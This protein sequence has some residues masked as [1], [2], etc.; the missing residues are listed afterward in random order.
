MALS[1]CHSAKGYIENA[2]SD[3]YKLNGL[4]NTWDNDPV[5]RLSVAIDFI[6]E[7][8]Q[9][10]DEKVGKNHIRLRVKEKHGHPRESFYDHIASMIFEVIF[11]A[12]AV[13]S[14]SWEC[15]T[16]QHNSVWGKLFDFQRMNNPA[17]SIV[18]FKLRRLLYDEVVRMKRFP[19]FKGAKILSFCLNVMGLESSQDSHDRDSR[20]LHKAILAWTKKNYAWLHE[21]NARI[22]EHCLVDGLIYE[23]DNFRI[24]KV[25]PAEGLRRAPAYVYLDIDP[26]SATD[27]FLAD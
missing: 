17:G 19:N 12:A 10:L 2:A 9:I 11:H 15:W 4:S 20:P 21:Y 22:A 3:L 26:P 13:S 23:P 16:I 6:L 27:E 5:R 8:I 1:K 24:V 14:P 7:T 25:Y 18:K